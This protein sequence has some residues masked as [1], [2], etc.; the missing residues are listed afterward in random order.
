[1]NWLFQDHLPVLLNS[2]QVF[3]QLYHVVLFVKVFVYSKER[4]REYEKHLSV[5]YNGVKTNTVNISILI[6]EDPLELMLVLVN[7]WTTELAEIT[8]SSLKLQKTYT[9]GSFYISTWAIKN[10]FTLPSNYCAIVLIEF[11]SLNVYLKNW[12]L[13]NFHCFIV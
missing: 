3:C 6:L 13:F 12:H 4:E 5:V 8:K 10:I 9:R 2:N 11:I 1:M 7:H